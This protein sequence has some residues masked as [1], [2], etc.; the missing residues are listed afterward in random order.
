M[1]EQNR[2]TFYKKKKKQENDS[3]GSFVKI[4]YNNNSKNVTLRFCYFKIK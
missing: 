1:R 3:H 2:N 4:E